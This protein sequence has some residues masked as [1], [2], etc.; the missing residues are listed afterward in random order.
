MLV[1]NGFTIWSHHL[2]HIESIVNGKKHPAG[3]SLVLLMLTSV[4]AVFMV[5]Q[6]KPLS[7]T[8]LTN[9]FK[10]V[11]SL[12]NR[13]GL[14]LSLESYC[15]EY[16]DSNEERMAHKVIFATVKTFKCKQKGSHF[17][18]IIVGLEL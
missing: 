16:F 10:K 14:L 3:G 9:T 11:P 15:K 8:T 13:T 6:F 17:F 7:S 5:R 18:F 2:F 1:L 12:S 4:T